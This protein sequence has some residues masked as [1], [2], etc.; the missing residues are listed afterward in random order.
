MDIN[1]LVKIT[2]RAWSLSI[3]GLMHRGVPGRQAALLAKSGAGRTAFAHSLKHLVDLGLLER[4]PGHGHPLRPEF[5]LTEKGKIAAHIA[6]Q[7][8]KSS[9][10]TLENTLLRRAWTVPILAVSTQPRFFSDLKKELPSITDR[11]LS[12]SLKQL[13]DQHW[14]KRQI[15][16]NIHPPRALYLA[17]NEGAS[18]GNAVG[19]GI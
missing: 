14:V 10:Q 1:L 12:Q 3:L 7:I 19:L 18:I 11:A 13:E 6:D 8:E 9:A 2:A 4:T 15:N 17:T 16:T 5:Q